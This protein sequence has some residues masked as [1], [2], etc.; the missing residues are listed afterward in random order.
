[1]KNTKKYLLPLFVMI[2]AAPSTQLSANLFGGQPSAAEELNEFLTMESGHKSTWFE[3]IKEKHDVLFNHLNHVHQQ[4]FAFKKE[5]FKELA[6][7]NKPATFRKILL[8]AIALHEKQKSEWKRL[9]GEER[10][11]AEMIVKKTDQELDSFKEKIKATTPHS[12]KRKAIE[13]SLG[14]EAEEEPSF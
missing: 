14:F 4:W 3:F 8:A 13:E 1:M 2:F 10:A 5:A 7:S 11:K 6:Q 12:H 9:C